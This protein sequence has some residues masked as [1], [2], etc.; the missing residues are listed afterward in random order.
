MS[1]LKRAENSAVQ[2]IINQKTNKKTTTFPPILCH[3]TVIIPLHSTVIISHHT[4]VIIPHHTAVIIHHHT[5]VIIYHHTAV[6][7]PIHTAVTIHHHTAVIIHLHT[8]GISHHHTAV[9]IPR[10][11]AVIIPCSEYWHASPALGDQ[12]RRRRGY[13]GRS[14]QPT[15]Q[16][17]P[18]A[19]G[20]ERKSQPIYLIPS[21]RAIIN[22]TKL[23][24]VLSCTNPGSVNF[25]YCHGHQLCC[26]VQIL[27]Q[28]TLH[29]VMGIKSRLHF[30][31]LGVG[32]GVTSDWLLISSGKY[33]MPGLKSLHAQMKKLQI[34]L[35]A[36]LLRAHQGGPQV[37]K[38]E[39]SIR[40]SSQKVSPIVIIYAT[41]RFQNWKK[42][43]E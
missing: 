3:T 38:S 5:T 26:R 40:N 8:A 7:I 6:I 43:T 39:E 25:V 27:G 12:S 41:L 33:V 42:K 24:I 34:L 28:L 35:L 19:C 23:W 22:G 9:I 15:W 13:R 17:T 37:I 18:C 10:H 14:H 21:V 2:V 36:L 1:L 29:I 4:T 30:R 11:T 31:W 32:E 20:P 16:R